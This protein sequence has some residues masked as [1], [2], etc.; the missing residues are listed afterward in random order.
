M[1]SVARYT[2]YVARAN[3]ES[4]AAH[5]HEQFALENI[6]E[7]LA[8]VSVGLGMITWLPCGYIRLISAP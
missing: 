3:T 5:E 1:Q 2:K 6:V 8:I 7:L 4:F